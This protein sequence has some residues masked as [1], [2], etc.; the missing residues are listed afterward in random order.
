MT[1]SL[2]DFTQFTR[3]M[4]NSDRRLRPLDQANGLT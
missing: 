3:W 1:E 2:Q 4:Q